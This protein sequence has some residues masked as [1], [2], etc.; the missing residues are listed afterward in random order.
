LASAR[1]IPIPSPC[2]PSF[3]AISVPSCL[4]FRPRVAESA[5]VDAWVPWAAIESFWT[6]QHCSL[7]PRQPGSL[8][9]A[10]GSGPPTNS[11]ISLPTIPQL[12]HPKP[13]I[14]PAVGSAQHMHAFPRVLVG[15]KPSA[16]CV[17]DLCTEDSS[18]AGTKGSGLWRRAGWHRIASHRHQYRDAPF[19][20][21][22]GPF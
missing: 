8:A 21:A 18:L 13:A 7:R 12:G 17:A 11:T 14:P 20:H 6:T 15:R 4:F 22:R 10:E 1:A 5:L 16:Q 3:R 19:R 2:F 9:E